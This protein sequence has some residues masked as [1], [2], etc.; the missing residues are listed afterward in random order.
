MTPRQVFE[1]V[2]SLE[3]DLADFYQE[4]G[5][6]ERLKPFA[7]I[8]SFMTDHS[9]SHA[10]RIEKMASATEWPVLNTAPIKELHERLKSS[11]GEQIRQEEDNAAVMQLLARTED[12]IGQLY[13]SV[14]EHYQRLSDAYAAVAAQF[15]KLSSEEFG[16]RDYILEEIQ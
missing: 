15:G 2:V 4:I 14:A 16:H 6:V 5:Q 8:F 7:D 12:V 13:Q 10:D 11:L 9:A 1:L 3:N